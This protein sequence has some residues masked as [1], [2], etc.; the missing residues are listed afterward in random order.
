MRD[1]YIVTDIHTMTYI[2]TVTDIH[3]VTYIYTVTDIQTVTAIYTVTDI[4]TVI[5]TQKHYSTKADNKHVCLSQ[6]V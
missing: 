5:N 6:F 1:V 4:H 2:H 3:T